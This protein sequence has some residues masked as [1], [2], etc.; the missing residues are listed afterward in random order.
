MS[1][2]KLLCL[3]LLKAGF[4]VDEK[5]I[6]A[7]C[8]HKGLAF[9]DTHTRKHALVRVVQKVEN[10]KISMEE[11]LGAV[12]GQ[13]GSVEGRLGSI[14]AQLGFVQE[15]LSKMRQL[16]S[17]VSEK[18]AEG[19]PGGSL[20]KGEVLDA[21]TAEPSLRGPL[22]AKGESAGGVDEEHD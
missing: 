12:E 2:R 14:E 9:S 4:R 22:L 1:P 11:R 6:C 8:E 13:L 19:F 16:F 5:F 17:K 10:S 7:D 18:G 15:E 3:A 21:V 20:T